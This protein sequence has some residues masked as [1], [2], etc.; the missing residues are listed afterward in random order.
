[1]PAKRQAKS[2]AIAFGT[3]L[4]SARL[5]A[6]LTQQRLAEGA[7]IDPVFVS[8]LENGQRQPSLTVVLSL[9]RVLG[10]GAGELSSRTARRLRTAA[11]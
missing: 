5:K 7:D 4:R 8:F 3:E 1:M 11:K 2:V 6:K 10:L 9:E